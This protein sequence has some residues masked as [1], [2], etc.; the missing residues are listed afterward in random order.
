MTGLTLLLSAQLAFAVSADDQNIIS[1]LQ[2]VRQQLSQSAG[3]STDCKTPEAANCNFQDYCQQFA[4][5]GKDFY[6]YQNAEGRQVYNFHLIDNISTAETCLGKKFSRAPVQDPFAYPEQLIDPVK[7]GSSQKV[8]ENFQRYL[9]EIKRTEKIFSDVQD[10]MVQVLKSRR[11]QE[12]SKAI[13]NMIA[14]I[15]TV[16]ISTADANEIATP[17]IKGCDIP[18]AGYNPSD[19]KIT[20]CPQ[21]MNLP[22]AALFSILAH[23]LAHPIDPCT[24]AMSYTRDRGVISLSDVD[25]RTEEPP[26]K[27]PF[28][29]AIKTNANPFKST[30]S[31][32]Q[33]PESLGVQIPQMESIVTSTIK[34][35]EDAIG[36]KEEIAAYQDG[37]YSD[38][39]DLARAQ[40]EEKVQGIRVHYPEFKQCYNLSG[41][42]HMTEAFADWM[43]S[44]VLKQKISDIPDSGIAKTYAAE[45]QMFFMAISCQNI[46]QSAATVVRP[47]IQGKCSGQLADIEATRDAESPTHPATHKR[48][49]RIMYA[50]AEIQKALGCKKDAGLIECK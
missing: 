20:V 31:C 19:H 16:K 3:A 5:K 10:R 21:L 34:E 37:M 39:T 1:Q 18:N 32:L 23:E 35:T 44:Q 11:T 45:S 25:F 41:S 30:I 14:R 24:M 42:G 40:L 43:S 26:P 47:L 27:D 22:D 36:T 2:K 6:L 29:A 15:T 33:K 49:S 9:K 13:D 4:G 38:V 12:N 50:P 48:V 7:A 46:A 17:A 28:F 8:R